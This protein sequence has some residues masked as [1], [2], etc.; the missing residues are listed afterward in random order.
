MS[1]GSEVAPSQPSSSNVASARTLGESDFPAWAGNAGEDVDY[2][3]VV[4][5]LWRRKV[6][7]LTIVVG[8]TGATA[9]LVFALPRHYVAHALVVVSNVDGAAWSTSI[10]AGAAN[11]PAAILPDAEAVQTEVEILQSPM[12]AAE[13][14]RGLKL[15]NRK[16]FNPSI[17]KPH[18]SL[19]AA[20][21]LTETVHNFLKRLHVD[22][23]GGSRVIDVAF[24]SESP[25]VAAKVV[26]T[27]VDDYVASQV[28]MR[29]RAAKQQG[30][31]L[32]DRIDQLQSQTAEDEQAIAEYRARA[33]LYSA[34]GGSPL[35]LREMAETSDQLASAQAQRMVLDDRLRQLNGSMSSNTDAT[36][37]LLSSR[38]MIALRT[39]EADLQAQLALNSQ[40]YG[41]SYPATRALG[42][43]I[44]SLKAQMKIEAQQITAAV[45]NEADLA[46]MREQQLAERLNTLQQGVTK[47]NTA[48]VTLGSL[49]RQAEA[50]RLVLNNYLARYKEVG[51]DVDKAALRPGSQIV[52]YA[53]VPV[54]SAEPRRAL[55]IAIAAAC[56][57]LG[58][59]GFVLFREKSDRTFRSIGEL[60]S[61]TGVTGLGLIPMTQAVTRSPI[62]LLRYGNGS[63]Y[64]EA[65]KA[66]YTSLFFLPGR[67]SKTTVITSAYP[68]EGKTTL[69]LSLAILA[70]QAGQRTVLIDADFWRAAASKA[71][72]QEPHT[73]GLAEVLSGNANLSDALI[74]DGASGIDI[75]PP[76]KFSRES[77]LAKVENLAQL[78]GVL[79]TRYDFV[80]IDS[81]PVFAV[82]EALVLAS[83]ADETIV[84]VRWAKTPRAAVTFALKR[85]RE[86]GA[87]VAGTV[88][89][90]VD[91][92]E[93]ALYGFGESAYFSKAVVGYYSRP[94]AISWSSGSGPPKGPKLSS[95]AR[96]FAASVIGFATRGRLAP[97]WWFA[98]S[99]AVPPP[100]VVPVSQYKRPR[101]ALL[102][103]DVQQDFTTS[104]G[105]FSIPTAAVRQ[106]VDVVSDVTKKARNSGIFVAYT[107]QQLDRGLAKIASRL[108][109][110]HKK[111]AADVRPLDPRIKS[112][113]GRLFVK[114][115]ADAFS[116]D[117]LDQFLRSRKV[118]H[119]FL[120]GIGG[121]TS[122]AQT[123]RSA[124][125]R[126]YKV[127]F[128]SDGIFTTSEKKWARMLQDFAA[129]QAFAITSRDFHEMFETR[130]SPS[131]DGNVAAPRRSQ[132]VGSANGDRRVALTYCPID[133]PNGI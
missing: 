106:M 84:A 66:I 48:N 91:Q 56:S 98:V 127:T 118:N 93:H 86:A 129:D 87:N 131:D 17:S 12:L 78:L 74:S 103:I 133:Q 97:S 19:P 92:R 117:K 124:L 2:L 23:R 31:W 61:V 4:R 52:S 95:A 101:E 107:Q 119:L 14:V 57:L 51:Q 42:A 99:R 33:G 34:P 38:V 18:S 25:T 39:R 22:T 90:L 5:H 94:D 21:A 15:E 30:Q 40:Q 60:E 41:P 110:R 62:G 83:H 71:Y 128:I 100:K 109:L 36:S 29:T 68:S 28:A 88:L 82:S 104:Y 24:D 37:D 132:K 43:Q 9:A 54:H 49:Q 26:N 77:G 76:G 47:M 73:Q 112:V 55:S 79:S 16:E 6:F 81:P 102:V 113:S 114:P 44:A 115:V 3:A 32:K 11:A 80:I 67:K 108:L 10:G 123:A 96:R 8:F 20:T 50:D 120:M 121:A 45:K 65:V 63:P 58:G 85:L 75:L 111:S 70:A 126:G 53:Q 69:A 27:L 105:L 116:S 35:L 122:I 13:V 64:R 130:V 1:H 89:T 46:R 7:I 59:C 125:K 72:A